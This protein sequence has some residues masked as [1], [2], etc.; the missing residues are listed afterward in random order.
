MKREIKFRVWDDDAEIMIYSDGHEIENADYWW[1]I[2]PLRLGCVTGSTDG[3]TLE[4]LEPIVTYYDKIMQLT[5]LED[6]NGREIWEGDILQDTSNPEDIKV[7]EWEEEL[8]GFMM[9]LQSYCERWYEVIGNIY[10][11]PEIIP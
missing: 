2:D 7:V 3:N 8:A 11:N 1:E 10:E 6:K 9:P 4:P 5:G